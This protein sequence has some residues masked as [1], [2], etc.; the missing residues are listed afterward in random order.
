MT[1]AH[2]SDAHCAPTR[3]RLLDAAQA[4][5][6]QQSYAATSMRQ[7]AEQGGLALGGIYNHFCS[8]EEIFTALLLER[9]IF[10]RPDQRF[11]SAVFDRQQAKTLLED[12]YAHPDFFHLI[13]IELMEFK[14]RHLSV[15]IEQTASDIPPS[16]WNS[17]FSL[18]VSF[19]ATQILLASAF[20]PGSQPQPSIDA[21]LN[22]YLNGGSTQEIGL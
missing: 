20:P 19:G 4:L 8:K 11:S 16:L 10:Q 13:L 22:N 21:F 3:A 9:N 5:F 1:A 6:A 14:G 12:I 17:L 15:L 7:I 2:R 18:V